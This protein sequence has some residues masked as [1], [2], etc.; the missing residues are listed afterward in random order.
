MHE[1]LTC[2]RCP[3]GCALVATVGEGGVVTDVS[4]NA[5]RRG[6]EYARAEIACP[7]RTVTTTVP[8]EGSRALRMLPVRTAGEVP[9]ARVLDVVRELASVRAQAPVKVGDVVL[10]DAAG[11]GVDVVAT[12]S[13]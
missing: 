7:L 5:C 4:G 13:A 6:V 2:I 8:V 3:R 12:A 11:T 1:R 9:R 10:R